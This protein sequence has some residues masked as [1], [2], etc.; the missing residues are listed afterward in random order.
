[1]SVGQRPGE[2]PFGHEFLDGILQNP[3]NRLILDRFASFGFEDWWLTAGCLAQTIWNIK[4]NRAPDADIADYD[5]FYFDSDTSWQAEDQVIAQGA[6]SAIRR[7]CRSG[8]RKS[9]LCPMALYMPQAMALIALP[10]RQV[11]LACARRQAERDQM[12]IASMRHL[13][14][15]R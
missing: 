1:M 10:I 13:A 5:L 8:I 7:G 2:I 14:L 6:K 4:A 12:P 11:R 15:V 9:L 3:V